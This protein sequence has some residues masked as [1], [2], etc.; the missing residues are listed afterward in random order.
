M[1]LKASPCGTM[2][3]A[4]LAPQLPIAWGGGCHLGRT[5][6]QGRQ[7]V[8]ND[9]GPGLSQGL[10][11]GIAVERAHPG[12]LRARLGKGTRPV[13]GPRHARDRVDLA[14]QSCDQRPADRTA[15]PC[16]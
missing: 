12:D 10:V 13:L 7:L 9:L 6:G 14:E 11:D 4:A 3:V 8:D 5:L 15:G 16:H 1:L 2:E